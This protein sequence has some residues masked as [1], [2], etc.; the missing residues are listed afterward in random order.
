[1]SA[2]KPISDFQTLIKK[3]IAR[4]EHKQGTLARLAQERFGH[5]PD[6]EIKSA[7]ISNWRYKEI[8][9][10][11][12]WQR[13]VA[14]AAV[15]RL[16]RAEADELCRSAKLPGLDVL[17][18]HYMKPEEQI[19]FDTWM[20]PVFTEQLQVGLLEIREDISDTKRALGKLVEEV[21]AERQ[22][23]GGANLAQNSP[24]V[25]PQAEISNFIGREGEECLKPLLLDEQT[26]LS[27][28]DGQQPKE[29][30]TWLGVAKKI[31]CGT[32]LLACCAILI[33]Y[34]LSLGYIFFLWIFPKWILRMSG[35]TNLYMFLRGD[36]KKTEMLKILIVFFSLTL[37]WFMVGAILSHVSHLSL[38]TVQEVWI[39]GPLLTGILLCLFIGYVILYYIVKWPYTD[40]MNIRKTMEI[41]AVIT[42]LTFISPS[43]GAS[44]IYFPLLTGVTS[45][46]L[47]LGGLVSLGSTQYQKNSGSLNARLE[48]R[49][50]IQLEDERQSKVWW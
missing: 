41:I 22:Q 3:Y 20:E 38:F 16:S 5:L 28:S 47:F 2:E 45:F 7:A 40:A 21:R 29:L 24:S 17:Q 25:L 48:R 9:S 35:S 13:L 36:F 26:S 27:T 33:A 23:E 19:L 34:W 32:R 8:T 1:M 6:F 50:Q 31:I 30:L 44:F 12:E 15:L 49:L 43:F 37:D 39:Y 10:V 4:S 18:K 11:R 46:C 14:L 42:L